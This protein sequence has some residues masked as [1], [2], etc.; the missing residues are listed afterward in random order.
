M[1]LEAY[2]IDLRVGIVPLRYIRSKGFDVR[3]ARLWISDTFVQAAF[4]GGGLQFAEE[5][6][7]DPAT[8]KRFSLSAGDAEPIADFSGLECRWKNVPS[9]RGEIVTLIVQAIRN[10]A[11]QQNETYREVIRNVGEIYGTDALCRPVHEADLSMT[12]S[13]KQLSGE[14]RIRS[15]QKG[16]TYRIAYWF[17]IRYRV[18]L[19]NFLMRIKRKTKRV[20]WGMYKR[21]VAANTDFKKFDD[22]LRQVLSGTSAQR[23]QLKAY[24]EKKYLARELVYGTQVAQTAIVTCLIFNYNGAHLHLV[25]SDNG[26]YAVAAAEMKERLQKIVSSK[27]HRVAK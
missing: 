21:D 15:F 27:P 22:K 5:C 4:S 6:L 14:S 13:E 25:D 24:L 9:A 8:E 10:S 17:K 12:L 18:L 7:K 20:D 26:G 2:G 23:E 19:G 3:V 11:K 1:A 16:T